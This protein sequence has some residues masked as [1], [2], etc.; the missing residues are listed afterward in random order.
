MSTH[1]QPT[2]R[3]ILGTERCPRC[4]VDTLPC[5]L[6]GKCLFCGE[7]L[8][9]LAEMFRFPIDRVRCQCG[10]GVGAHNDVD[11]NCAGC[12]CALFTPAEVG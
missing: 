3:E 7:Q 4:Q 9:E 6:T 5:E 10:H 1:A 12:P 11:G 8:V 2:S